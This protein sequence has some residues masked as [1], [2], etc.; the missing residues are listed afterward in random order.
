[1]TDG[2][3]RQYTVTFDGLTKTGVQYHADVTFNTLAPTQA[4][5]KSPVDHNGPSGYYQNT[6]NGIVNYT[7]RLGKG[8]SYDTPAGAGVFVSSTTQTNANFGGEF[9]FIQTGNA[10][11]YLTGNGGGGN[12][13]LRQINIGDGANQDSSTGNLGYSI[14]GTDFNPM[15]TTGWTLLANQNSEDHS[16]LDSPSNSQA[17]NGLVTESVGYAP[18]PPGKSAPDATPAKYV[19]YLCYKG[20]RYPTAWVALQKV[21]WQW[22]AVA[23]T[24]A[25]N[26]ITTSH[27][28]GPDP[29]VTS[30][31]GEWPSWTGLLRQ[32]PFERYNP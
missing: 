16:M 24:T 26:T 30:A 19:T 23:T 27:F 11:N 8:D 4:T 21:S 20:D 32:A 1:M 28:T 31:L 18:A 15:P 7:L 22:T 13:Y 6:P 9:A 3:Q 25:P 10:F 29:V 14:D 17:A 12:V 5:I 2:T